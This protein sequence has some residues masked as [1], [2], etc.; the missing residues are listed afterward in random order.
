[1]EIYVVVASNRPTADLQA[2]AGIKQIQGT[3]IG[4]EEGEKIFVIR[5]ELKKD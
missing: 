3:F 4:Q 2:I 1:L 5:R